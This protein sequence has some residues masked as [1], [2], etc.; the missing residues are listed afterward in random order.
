MNLES[1][2][3]KNNYIIKNLYNLIETGRMPHAIIIEGGAKDTRKDIAVFLSMWAVCKHGAQPED[4]RK[5]QIKETS[6]PPGSDS[7][8]IP[9]R[10][11]GSCSQCIKAASQNHSDIRTASG[12]GKTD[13]ISIS[14]IRNITDDAVIIPN[15]ANNKVY[16]FYEADQRMKTEAQNALLKTL[17]EPPQNILFLITCAKSSGLLSTILS[18]ATVFSLDDLQVVSDE[19]LSISTEII[20]SI[21]KTTEFDLLASL[22]KLNKKETAK[23]IL[24]SVYYLLA[25]SLSISKSGKEAHTVP[26]PNI[27]SEKIASK[28]TAEKIIKLL[29][30]T[31]D[32]LIKIDTNVNLNLL[33][34]WISGQYRRITWQKS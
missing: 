26:A 16:I 18:R 15:E 24:L 28:L 27:V 13:I 30:L 3:Q 14:E 7:Y 20:L 31:N 23:Q 4:A 10:P 19:I 21:L 2:K 22:Y 11:C 9:N 29:E 8:N 5:I 25:E 33:S 17:E 6:C 34:T 1:F 12:S 32:A